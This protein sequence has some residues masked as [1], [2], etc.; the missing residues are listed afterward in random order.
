MRFTIYTLGDVQLFEGAFQGIAMMYQVSS[1]HSI[2]LWTSNMPMGLGIGALLG[3]LMALLL[4]IYTGYQ[5][6]DLDFRSVLLPLILY[7]ALTV[8]KATVVI[9][10]SYS[11]EA[12]VLVDN[13]PIGLAFPMGVISGIAMSATTQLENIYYV[14]YNGFTKITDQGYV[15][16]LKLLH[17][18]RYTGVSASAGMPLLNSTLQEVASIC[19]VNNPDF[20]SKN[21]KNKIDGFSEFQLALQSPSVANRYVKVPLSGALPYKMLTCPQASEYI[22]DSLDAYMAGTNSNSTLQML[23]NVDLEKNNLVSDVQ[24]GLAN[25]EN[26][27]ENV[28]V[29]YDSNG[30]IIASIGAMAGAS[31]QEVLQFLK[32]ALLDTTLS[33]VNHCTASKLQSDKAKCQNYVTAVE[34]WKEKSASDAS[35]FASIM[36]D[37]QNLLIILSIILFPLVLLIVIIKG[38]SSFKLFGSYILFA[39]CA[40]MW[41]P[42]ASIINFYTHLQLYEA[43]VKFNPTNDP[44]AVLS[45]KNA[46]EF[47]D[48][49]SQKLALANSALATVPMLCI[50]LFSGMLMTINSLTDK[51]NTQTKTY[52]EKANIPDTVKRG[53]IASVGSSVSYGNI[54]AKAE[55]SGLAQS[56][57]T[58]KNVEVA[59]TLKQQKGAS[60][61]NTMNLSRMLDDKNTKGLSVDQQWT[62]AKNTAEKAST[63]HTSQNAKDIVTAVMHS[64][65]FGGGD[66][67]TDQYKT[68]VNKDGST[69]VQLANGTTATVGLKVG[70]QVGEDPKNANNP[71]NQNANKKIGKEADG[72]L[73]K[74]LGKTAIGPELGYQM[75]ASAKKIFQDITTVGKGWKNEAGIQSQ[76]QNQSLQDTTHG[77]TYSRAGQFTHGFQDVIAGEISSV[78]SENMSNQKSNTASQA[79]SKKLTDYE[80]SSTELSQANSYVIEQKKDSA[81]LANQ[82]QWHPE[83]VSR[84]K[85]NIQSSGLQDNL[86]YQAHVQSALTSLSEANT[87]NIPQDVLQVLA[88]HTALK[89]MGGQIAV[90]A[91]SA[92]YGGYEQKTI[93]DDFLKDRDVKGAVDRTLEKVDIEG[94]IKEV[95]GMDFSVDIEGHKREVE[96]LIGELDQKAN[97]ETYAYS[98]TPDA[99]EQAKADYAQDEKD[100]NLFHM[101]ATENAP[102]VY[103]TQRSDSVWQDLNT[104]AG[105]TEEKLFKKAENN[106]EEGDKAYEEGRYFAGTWDKAVGATQVVVA[107]AFTATEFG[108]PTAPEATALDNKGNEVYK[109]S[110]IEARVN[111]ANQLENSEEYQKQV[112]AK[113]AER[114]IEMKNHSIDK[115]NDQ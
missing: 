101:D 73:K 19:L 57:N 83:M 16:P 61:K 105:A 65:I 99:I 33:T 63:A 77:N 40:F 114:A 100:Y 59:N 48:A 46:P 88:E 6:K 5:K 1:G 103:D 95:Q 104:N 7:F 90:D 25:Q 102:I 37:G 43:M 34:Q 31:N 78:V 39:I 30:E 72:M 32:T 36:R 76:D 69:V 10:D 70:V 106:F 94:R 60:E 66:V 91:I 85:D 51:W 45:L 26:A 110:A 55:V 20:N 62:V 41:L 42:V 23:S 71:D 80:R 8:P 27:N 111:T 47:Y 3:A 109:V 107:G 75:D 29:R 21:Y 22:S 35:G 28:G 84:I 38:V 87:N 68:Y 4:M 17:A 113:I 58:S 97:Q 92:E 67:T 18:I 89:M 14:P 108:T 9:E 96:G 12:P 54:G 52:D 112:D 115:P 49:V 24:K 11:Q 82:T 86:Q 98:I 50:G 64:Q 13:V 74:I 56:Q 15:A 93:Q 79:W 2:D 53:P 44:N 81:E